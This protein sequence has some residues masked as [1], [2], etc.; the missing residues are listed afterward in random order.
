MIH[1]FTQL[2]VK[3]ITILV[4]YRLGNMMHDGSAIKDPELVS[5]RT[6]SLGSKPELCAM[7]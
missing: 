6:D 1:G 2:K 5:W 3:T 7:G 4:V